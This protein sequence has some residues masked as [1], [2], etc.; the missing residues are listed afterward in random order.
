MQQHNDGLALSESMCKQIIFLFSYKQN[1][2]V[3]NNITL[4]NIRNEIE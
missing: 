2:K 4:I 3:K 1:V